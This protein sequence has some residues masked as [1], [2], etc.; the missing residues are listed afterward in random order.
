MEAPDSIGTAAGAD[1][2]AA[3][4]D[5]RR[6]R[7]VLV[8]PSHC[9]NIGASAR[10]IRTMGFS[11]LTVVA[12]REPAFR[13][14]AQAVALAAHARDVLTGA[15]A[16]D[17]IVDALAGVNLAI[18]MTGYA[19]ER[20]PPHVDLREAARQAAQ[21]IREGR[22]AVALVFGTERSGLLN[23]DVQ[24]CQLSCSIGAD[25]SCASLNLAQAV[26]VAAYALRCEL[27]LPGQAPGAPVAAGPSRA[28]V[29]QSERFFESLEQ[30]LEKIGFHDPARPRHLMARLRV[31]F[32]RA[33]PSTEEMDL[34]LG[35]CAA[36]IEPKA[37]RA[38]RK[39][40]PR[41]NPADA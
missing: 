26:Q 19:R 31:L 41:G 23:Q 36:I 13:E 27:L 11:G 39:S 9:G 29:E 21:W 15:S 34:L 18:A 24:R 32:N 8:Q 10:A 2:R 4:Y 16:H 14:S 1:G 38:G 30:A 6:L 28:H 22:G 37:R 35:I 40:G 20:S 25:V 7:F 3:G 5:A 17:S 12:P 33:A